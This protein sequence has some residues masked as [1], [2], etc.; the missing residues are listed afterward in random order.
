MVL[1]SNGTELSGGSQGKG[2]EFPGVIK[3]KSCGI[4]WVL[5]FFGLG[6]SETSWVLHNFSFEV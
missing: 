2:V 4:S 3:S 6:I 5:V 1:K